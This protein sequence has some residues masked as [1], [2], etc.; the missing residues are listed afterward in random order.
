MNNMILD[1]KYNSVDRL[2]L[3]TSKSINVPK[4]KFCRTLLLTPSKVQYHW[5][6][7]RCKHQNDQFDIEN[8]EKYR[9]TARI[10]NR[11]VKIVSTTV[12]SISK[13]SMIFVSQNTK[14]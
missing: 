10:H 5:Q 13:L 7:N 12:H 9:L 4:S 3:L 14:N 8:S 1:N 6:P 11:T 2:Y